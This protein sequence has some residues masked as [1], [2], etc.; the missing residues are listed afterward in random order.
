MT[1]PT[2]IT[3]TIPA[4][5]AVLSET[6]TLA[7]PEEWTD[8]VDLLLPHTT[9]GPRFRRPIMWHLSEMTRDVLSGHEDL[10]RDH[11]ESALGWVD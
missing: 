2:Y 8:L 11:L 5:S 7:H 4:Y 3:R 1:E 9:F 6:F 10:A